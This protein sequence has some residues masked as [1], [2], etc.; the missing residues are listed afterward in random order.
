M[1][2]GG[3]DLGEATAPSGEM[4]ITPHATAAA[5][6]TVARVARPGHAD[7]DEREPPA[8]KGFARNAAWLLIAEATG[9]VASFLFVVVVARELGARDYGAFA[10]AVAFVA[11]FYRLSA[12]GVDATVISEVARDHRKVREVFP[13]GLAL[14]AGFGVVALIAALAI[15]PLFVDGRTAYEAFA[16]LGAALLL[17]EMSQFLSALFRSFERM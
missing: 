3:D 17:D 7:D 13:A 10:F 2:L 11:P 8:P 6:T 16:I 9:K 15:A 12:W 14:R 5:E 1:N 4:E